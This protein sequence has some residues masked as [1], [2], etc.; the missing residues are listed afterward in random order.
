M[1]QLD[2]ESE[3]AK[4]IAEADRLRKAEKFLTITTGK[5]LCV[6]CGYEYEEKRGDQEY[7]ITP[8]TKFSVSILHVPVPDR[9]G[10]Y[11]ARLL[12]CCICC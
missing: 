5:A 3:E 7:P 2:P 8:G 11:D 4:K 12:A 9:T 1:L 6:S 10:A